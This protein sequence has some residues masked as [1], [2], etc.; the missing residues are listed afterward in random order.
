MPEVPSEPGRRF[1]GLARKARGQWN[2]PR[3]CAASSERPG[4]IWAAWAL[5]ML[6]GIVAGIAPTILLLV[7]RVCLMTRVIHYQHVVSGVVTQPTVVDW[8]VSCGSCAA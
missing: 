7:A 5:G 4:H 1:R 2:D 3:S 6:L 8:R